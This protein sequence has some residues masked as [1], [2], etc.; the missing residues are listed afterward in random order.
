MIELGPIDAPAA[1]PFGRSPART[2]PS[3][4]ST[5]SNAP[6]ALLPLL[7][8]LPEIVTNCPSDG[9]EGV[10]NRD[11]TTRSGWARAGAESSATSP[12]TTRQG[13]GELDLNATR[14]YLGS[15]PA[16]F[17]IGL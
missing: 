9:A 11:P 13:A 16:M 3:T 8:M 5:Q 2:I 1:R 17:S 4:R 6:A 15:N 12:T 14:K 7:P 10:A